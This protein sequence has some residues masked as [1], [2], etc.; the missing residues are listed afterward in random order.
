[1]M[2]PELDP[3]EQRR[4]ESKKH[5]RTGAYGR[6]KYGRDE[7]RRRRQD[8]RDQ[9][10]EPNM[11]DDDAGALAS[12]TRSSS[13]RRGSVSM[14]SANSS[15]LPRSPRE[16]RFRQGRGEEYH[17][18]R[19]RDRSAS[20]ST[21][22]DRANDTL[23]R[24][25]R[26]RTPPRAHSTV[27]R[28][29]NQ[30]ENRGKELFPSKPALGT[31]LNHGSKELFPNKKLAANLKKELF[32]TKAHTSHHR[33]SD[34]FDAADETADLFA[35]RLG[36]ANGP[37]VT[38]GLTAVESTYGRLNADSNGASSTLESPTDSGLS[39]RGASKQ[40]DQGFSIRG[41]AADGTRI[42]TIKE[43]FP[44]RAGGNAGKELFAEKLQGRGGKRNR[45]EDMFY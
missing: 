27:S 20:P 8:D 28:G 45:A 37:S 43:L 24:R 39:I 34:A 19:T 9:G 44:G 7:H 32:P 4:R 30:K 35:K 23:G 21:H 18:L 5:E 6:R 1:M 2:H 33:R 40:K 29:L 38:K 36:F 22:D 3:R 11:Y 13:R 25:D 10:F 17:K 16:G 14:H 31:A 42:G 41:V 26:R 15:E 12:R